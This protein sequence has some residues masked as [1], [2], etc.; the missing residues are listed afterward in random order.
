MGSNIIFVKKVRVCLKTLS[1]PFTKWQLCFTKWGAENANYDSFSARE[2]GHL[3]DVEVGRIYAGDWA[4]IPW[5]ADTPSDPADFK[6]TPSTSASHTLEY[7]LFT[8]E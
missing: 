7:M 8:D 6:I 4:F 3:H 5:S 1:I 2:Y